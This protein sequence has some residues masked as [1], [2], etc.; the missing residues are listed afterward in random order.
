MMESILVTGAFGI[1]GR[2]LV[3]ELVS[4]GIF[5]KAVVRHIPKGSLFENEHLVETRCVGDLSEGRFPGD[6]FLSVKTVVHCAARAHVMNE[7]GPKVLGFYR[8]NNTVATLNLA[9]RAAVDGVERFVFISTIKVNG[10]ETQLNRPFTETDIPNPTDPYAISKLEAEEGLMVIGK[11]TGMDI[12]IIR[13]PLVYGKGVKG[14]FAVLLK[15]INR[16]IPLPFG[17]VS[18]KRSLVAL[19]NLIN[20]VTICTYHPNAKN[21][22]FLAGDGIDVSTTHLLKSLAS[23]LQKPSRLIPFP[24]SILMLMALMIGRKDTMKRSLGCLQVDIGKSQRYLDWEPIISFEE[25][26]IR[27]VELEKVE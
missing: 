1:V 17:R 19:D 13:P 15:L 5:V 22:I 3:H 20:L 21:Q 16:G 26:I 6:I 2:A 25:G 7:Q 27:S 8:K 23:A 10:E 11:E 9:R 12:V 18:N 14:N 4:R 24:V